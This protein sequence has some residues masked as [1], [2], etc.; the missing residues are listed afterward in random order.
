MQA[1]RIGVGAAVLS[2][3]L[4]TTPASAGLITMFTPTDAA[5]VNSPPFGPVAP[6]GV[7]TTEYIG[8]GV[9]FTSTGGPDVAVFV[10]PREAWTGVNAWRT[11]R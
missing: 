6:G 11:R 2:A 9:D 8:F 10:D 5:H 4:L 3:A 7:I 1:T